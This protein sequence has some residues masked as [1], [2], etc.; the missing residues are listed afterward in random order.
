MTRF[1]NG[2]APWINST[3]L[4]RA[5]AAR[6]RKDSEK[7][8]LKHPK[9]SPNINASL[10]SP[11]SINGELSISEKIS[12]AEVQIKVIKQA[13]RK[14]ILK[15][16]DVSLFSMVYLFGFLTRVESVMPLNNA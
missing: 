7:G 13:N 3:S 2:N 5:F 14:T 4:Y 15:I 10:R 9:A 16:V 6:T 1:I 12:T 8:T 11:R